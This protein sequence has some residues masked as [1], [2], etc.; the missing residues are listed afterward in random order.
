[1]RRAPGHPAALGPVLAIAVA[2]LVAVATLTAPAT[3][4]TQA[5]DH[6]V[7]PLGS[8]AADAAETSDGTRAA[9]FPSVLHAIRSGAV[10]PGDRLVLQDGHHGALRLVNHSFDPPLRIEA[11]TPGAAHVERIAIRGGRGLSFSGLAVWPREPRDH[12]RL[13]HTTSDA[14]HMRFHAMDLRGSP[15]APDTYMTWSAEDWLATRRHSGARL[16]GPH[17]TLTGSRITATAFAITTMGPHAEVRGNIVEGFSGDAM[18]GLAS[19]AV[20]ADNRVANCVDVDGNHDDAFQSWARDTGGTGRAE[21]SDITIENNVMLEWIGAPDHP[22]RC[23]LQGIG[24]FNGPFRNFTIR[25]N[26]IAISAWHGISI[27]R[28]SDSRIVNNTLIHTSGGPSTDRPWIGVFES[29]PGSRITVANNVA[30]AFRGIPE[31]QRTNLA[32]RYPAR[33]FR[34]PATLDLAPLPDGPLV[35]A[36]QPDIAPDDDLLRRPRDTRPDLGAL[37][38]R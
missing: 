29:G 3:A 16:E 24:L 10:R 37:E 25:N 15:D 26:I 34:D 36:G 21:I 27:Y 9:P 20:F 13:I 11:E 4:Q 17:N 28:G 22:L 23:T 1:M 18:R 31:P 38:A 8:V 33:L 35:D 30:P 2:I 6:L 32:A 14:A 7:A 5:R 19:H 12:I